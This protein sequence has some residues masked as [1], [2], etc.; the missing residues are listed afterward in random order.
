MSCSIYD[1]SLFASMGSSPQ[2]KTDKIQSLIEPFTA[3]NSGV[4][5]PLVKLNTD[6]PRYGEL[7]ASAGLENSSKFDPCNCGSDMF[8]NPEGDNADTKG[9]VTIKDIFNSQENIMGNLGE[10]NY[11]SASCEAGN[12]CD[13]REEDDKPDKK[14]CDVRFNTDDYVPKIPYV[15]QGYISG[16]NDFKHL[17]EFPSCSNGGLGIDG[18]ITFEPLAS[19]FTDSADGLINIDWVLK[20]SIGEMPYDATSSRHVS[21]Y[22]HNKAYAK[23]LKNKTVGNFIQKSSLKAGIFPEVTAFTKP[24]GFAN[25]T[26][27]NM[28][29]GETKL[30]SHWKWNY[31]SGI[32]GWYRHF[33]IYRGRDK[34]PIPG[35]DLFIPSG[36]IFHARTIGPEVP[37]DASAESCPSGLKLVN[38][39]QFSH[40]VPHNTEFVYISENIY[41]KFIEAHKRVS[42]VMSGEEEILNKSLL[43]AT[44]PEYDNIITDL[45]SQSLSEDR[46]TVVGQ[47][48]TL[49]FNMVKGT[50]FKSAGNINY[51]TNKEDLIKTL[52][53]KYGCYHWIPPNTSSRLEFKQSVQ[54]KSSYY[55]DMSFDMVIPNWDNNFNLT[56]TWDTAS[57]F[58]PNSPNYQKEFVYNQY[59]TVGDTNILTTKHNASV[60]FNE[61]CSTESAVG[62]AEWVKDDHINISTVTSLNTGKSLSNNS[63]QYSFTDMY[64]AGRL[65]HDRIYP[66]AAFNPHVD[67][68][69]I[70]PQGG[71]YINALPFGLIQN[72]AFGN[73][74][75]SSPG[76]V[77]SVEFRT[78]D[79]GIK[80]YD[81][82]IKSLQSKKNWS[83]SCERF[84]YSQEDKCKCY[85]FGK[86]VSEYSR[87]FTSSSEAR[88]WYGGSTYVPNLS[89]KNS[90]L[91][92]KYGG[93]NQA[94]LDL[95]FGEDQ[96]QTKPTPETIENVDFYIS[97]LFPYGSEQQAS[98]T[99]PNY[100]N[101]SWVLNTKNIATNAHLDL[102]VGVSENVNL[103]ANRFTGDPASEDYLSNHNM[104][105]K[106]FTTKVTIGGKTI[107]DQQANQ[108][109]V[110]EEGS[111]TVKLSNPFLARLIND[112]QNAYAAPDNS[113]S[114]IGVSPKIYSNRGDESSAV[115]LTFTKKPRKQLLNFAI[116]PPTP[117]GT[118]KQSFFDPNKGLS[119]SERKMKS[120]FINN[121]VYTDYKFNAGTTSNLE[122]NKG[123]YYGTIQENMKKLCHQVSDFNFNRKL[124]TYVKQGNVWYQLATQKRGAYTLDNKQ[125][126]G[127]PR[128]F[129][130]LKNVN[131]SQRIPMLFP[132]P[133]RQLFA[134]NFFL[135]HADIN[136]ASVS[137]GIQPS[138]PW[139]NGRDFA[140]NR[141]FITMGGS[142]YYFT[143]EEQFN[144]VDLNIDGIGGVVGGVGVELNSGQLVKAG[145][146]YYLYNN[147]PRNRIDSYLFLGD[148][149]EEI[150]GSPSSLEIEY[151]KDIAPTNYVYNSLKVCDHDITVFVNNGGVITP[152][153]ERYKIISKQLKVQGYNA[154]GRPT[155]ANPVKYRLKTVFGLNQSMES[156][157]KKIFA[158]DIPNKKESTSLCIFH[159]QENTDFS[160]LLRIDQYGKNP[161]TGKWSDVIGLQD[162]DRMT[163]LIIDD[164][165]VKDIYPKSPY[166]NWFYKQIINNF[167]SR[168]D[169]ELYINDVRYYYPNIKPTYCILQKYNVENSEIVDLRNAFL[170][171]NYI[172]MMDVTLH[173]KDAK[174]IFKNLGDQDRTNIGIPIQG[175]IYSPNWT[176]NLNDNEFD[177]KPPDVDT[178]TFGEQPERLWTEITSDDRIETAYV[179]S[180]V[181][182][183]DTLR[184]DDPTF[185]LDSTFKRTTT[186]T[187]GVRTTFTPVAPTM[188][189]AGSTIPGF[190]HQNKTR[191]Y[192]FSIHNIYGDG[193]EFEKCGAQDF[194]TC[195]MTTR[196]SVG[197]HAKL[198]IATPVSANN[199]SQSHQYYTTYDAGLY[200][201]LGQRNLISITRSQLDSDNPLDSAYDHCSTGFLRP[202]YKR[203]IIDPERNKIIREG[204]AKAKPDAYVKT[205]DKYANEMLFRIMY[206]DQGDPVNRAIL[207]SKK[208]PLT[209]S[210]LVNFTDP[211]VT[212]ADVYDEILY[213]YD[214]YASC[215]DFINNSFSVRGPM[216]IGEYYDFT[217]GNK[218]IYFS[219]EDYGG[220]DIRA[221][222]RIGGTTFNTKLSG[223]S[224]SVKTGVTVTDVHT[225]LENTA[226]TTYT[227]RKTS[228]GSTSKYYGSVSGRIY[229]GTYG[230]A[231]RD[232]GIVMG[233][234]FCLGQPVG[235]IGYHGSQVP[236]GSSVSNIAID[237]GGTEFAYW[238]GGARVIFRGGR[239]SSSGGGCPD[240]TCDDYEIGYCKRKSGCNTDACDGDEDMENFL[241]SFRQCRTTFNVYGHKYKIQ[242]YV[243]EEEEEEEEP[244]PTDEDLPDDDDDDD[245]SD[246]DTGTIPLAG[247]GSVSLN[248]PS[249]SGRAREEGGCL[250]EC[251]GVRGASSTITGGCTHRCKN[252]C[253]SWGPKYASRRRVDELNRAWTGGSF[254]L[255]YAQYQRDTGMWS[256]HWNGNPHTS[257]SPMTG[258]PGY[259]V[260]GFATHRVSIPPRKYWTY[261]TVTGA[262]T[263]W[264]GRCP[265]S[266]CTISYTNNS[267]S[268]TIGGETHC[269]ENNIVDCPSLEAQLPA[270][271][272]ISAE[273]IGSSNNND[274]DNT[275]QINVPAQKQ[276]FQTL[277]YTHT[278]VLGGIS[279]AD[280][281]PLGA[282]TTAKSFSCG[283]FT[284]PPWQCGPSSSAYALCG[285]NTWWHSTI[286][287]AR[288]TFGMAASAWMSRMTEAFNNIDSEI[289]AEFSWHPKGPPAAAGDGGAERA[290]HKCNAN[291]H[292]SSSDIVQ[293]IIPG[294][295]SD[296]QFSISSKS[297]PKYGYDGYDLVSSTVTQY[298]IRAYITYSYKRPV[299]IQ[300]KLKG[301]SAD[302]DSYMCAQEGTNRTSQHNEGA[303]D[304][305]PEWYAQNLGLETR[306]TLGYPIQNY[307]GSNNY[308]RTKTV[309]SK[310]NSCGET[311]TSYTPQGYY[312][313]GN[314]K[315][316]YGGAPCGRNDYLCWSKNRDWIRVW[317]DHSYE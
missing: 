8:T 91:L 164:L 81:I 201:P 206:G 15:H 22:V 187:K 41:P 155:I 316:P 117:Y 120:P 185:W 156:I 285:G 85:A 246:D 299:T 52:L 47:L 153:S 36:D 4:W 61:T 113:E 184:I 94:Y 146:K 142:R 242:N 66:A 183:S 33:D 203:T 198:K 130:Y 108:V 147:G 179:P 75:T 93:Y 40:I 195:F 87:Q 137:Q 215:G 114:L 199:L 20:E 49:N 297:Y 274:D 157:K 141:E 209:V 7:L 236:P 78:K 45:Y 202:D 89:T 317:T 39:T 6:N 10:C 101:T 256:G 197:L 305:Y 263:P 143:V 2:I 28:F 35:I 278:E 218:N 286:P 252:R 84:P 283:L 71:S 112:H 168:C 136:N 253:G 237:N 176:R 56:E 51:C 46:N 166:N 132:A 104:A 290:R 124:R 223:S 161:R 212:A 289:G 229:T 72:T 67:L 42:D 207:L 210:D 250:I 177:V 175:Y 276:I 243:E 293:G 53:H 224:Y 249:G 314:P 247:G 271:A 109:T 194:S 257:D 309:V 192:A 265:R 310:S 133:P 188:S 233:N 19:D 152:I 171:Q 150:L 269:I 135:N 111:L 240:K 98:V 245:T 254:G 239:S 138:Y 262:S 308:I 275:M 287:D 300:D 34:R 204:L 139:L 154:K 315:Y 292:I 221:V 31:Q 97:P 296:I 241:Y 54:E 268:I 200:N 216:K 272:Y 180:S 86:S 219:V 181:V 189:S 238:I 160:P 110:A 230:I 96:V 226:N 251:G 83:K 273:N 55:I 129:E 151:D 48:S 284:I 217:I 69:A 208:K 13:M 38:G 270:H 163:E 17:G 16:F 235:D 260:C 123:I 58:L 122:D 303:Q 92:K 21:E 23:S 60:A 116:P 301:W 65:Q 172:P 205:L 313:N 79:C 145:T 280:V 255:A 167:E 148:R 248:C 144:I 264:D 100:V 312:K 294:T 307:G 291:N 231:V 90:P 174:Q 44:H 27:D 76:G 37:K 295:C 266:V 149:Y 173:N 106:R 281:N 9:T 3:L 244:T 182:Y 125:Y 126:L 214:I 70:H 282:V 5:L 11:C 158:I 14:F 43:L 95:L 12:P 279:G 159:H 118:L 25:Q 261:R 306:D 302:S 191:S 73:V 304:D 288:G 57:K 80:I 232:Y 102:I 32:M 103:T 211:K 196:G 165:E 190:S 267:L 213:N 1:K 64:Q 105:W 193:D 234:T 227:L 59:M 178:E 62:E 228:S 82:K 29:T 222:G 258:D 18:F 298:T 259:D 88:T 24:Y 277:T 77:V 107:Y 99:L 26:Y 127:R 186:S 169:F 162:P 74:T 63:G 134:W 140:I 50:D 128:L 30:G 121:R 170:Y 115:T 68:L 220:G 311:L 131:N 119:S 225:T